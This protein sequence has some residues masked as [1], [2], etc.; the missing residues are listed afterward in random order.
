MKDREQ[1]AEEIPKMPHVPKEDVGHNGHTH[2]RVDYITEGDVHD[3]KIGHAIAH[4][5]K[6]KNN[7]DHEGITS[8]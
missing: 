2:E 6:P 8:G 3:V 5:P 7:K 1:F 4:G